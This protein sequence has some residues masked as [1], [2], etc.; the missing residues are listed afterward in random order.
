M[1]SAGERKD[2]GSQFINTV[3]ELAGEDP[4]MPDEEGRYTVP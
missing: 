2:G 4:D 1:F 3:N